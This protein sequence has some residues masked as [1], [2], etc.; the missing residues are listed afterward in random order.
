MTDTNG[1]KCE[2]CK[3]PVDAECNCDEVDIETLWTPDAPWGGDTFRMNGKLYRRATK[4]ETPDFEIE[5]DYGDVPLRRLTR[6]ELRKARMNGKGE[7]I[8]VKEDE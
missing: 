7:M 6:G 8:P 2:V 4:R 3:A 1:A 5:T